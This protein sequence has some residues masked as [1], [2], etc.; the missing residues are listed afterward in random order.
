VW[1]HSAEQLKHGSRSLRVDESI[2]YSVEDGSDDDV[3]PVDSP[4]PRRCS[5]G[6]VK[7]ALKRRQLLLA[8]FIRVVGT[9]ESFH[10][11]QTGCDLDLLDR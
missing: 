5:S 9:Q 8:E 3:A 10:V 1:Q 11:R 7:V 6:I 4:E 2:E